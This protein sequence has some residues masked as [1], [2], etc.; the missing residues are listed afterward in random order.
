MMWTTLD[1]WIVA[2]GCLSA[3]SCALLGNYLVLRQMSMMGDAISHAVL[4]GLAVAFLVTLSRDSVTMFVGAAA[5]GVVTALLTQFIHQLGEVERSAAMGVVFTTLFA[6]GLILIVRAANSV[7]LDPGCVL[8]GAIELIPLNTTRFLGFDVP[9]A[10]VALGAV[11]AIDVLF[12]SLL[13]KELNI[14]SFDPALA[15]TLG[16]NS[17]LMHYL[18][19]TLVAVTAVAAFESVGSI[20]VIA[21]LIVPPAFAHLVTSRLKGMI[22]VSLGAAVLSAAGGHLSAITVPTLFGFSDTNT[23]GMMAVVSG[24]LFSL[25]MLFGPRNGLVTRAVDRLRVNVKVTGDDLLGLLY[26]LEE[27]TGL[28]PSPARVEELREAHGSILASRGGGPMSRALAMGSLR[29][30]GNVSREGGAV[31]LTV[32]GRGRARELVGTHRLWERYLFDKGTVALD[33]LHFPA[34]QLEHVSGP[35][36]RRELRREMK[37]PG[38]DPTGK[39]IP[40]D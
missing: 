28:R 15:T 1:T 30:A 18:L 10:V 16:I 22:A 32:A 12:V 35:E 33:H 23:A 37:A 38:S 2:A 11:F 31:M 14:S 3:M 9:R 34:H 40:G 27:R 29:R 5:I 17:R 6:V 13:Y 4:P 19:M 7:D 26:R 20:L 21:M 36:I 25:A 39:P 8:F 24:A